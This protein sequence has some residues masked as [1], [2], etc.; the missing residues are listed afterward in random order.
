M[1][2]KLKMGLVGCGLAATREILPPLLSPMGRDWI[3]VVAVC[4][5]DEDRAQQVA[6]QFG[7]PEYYTDHRK[8][9]AKAGLDMVGVATPIPSHFP[10]ALDAI[11]AGKH[12]YIQKTMTV[13]VDDATHLIEAAKV[14]EVKLVSSPGTHLSPSGPF[15]KRIV[16]AIIKY[17]ASGDVGKLAWGRVSMHMRHEHELERGSEGF[18]SIDPSW[19]YRSGGGPLRDLMV[20]AMHPLTWI[21]GPAKKVTA[22]SN[23]LL[24]DREW[25]SKRI[26]VEIDDCTT[27]ILEFASGVQITF[28][29]SFIKGSP[30]SPMAELVG[31][32][33]AIIIGGRGAQGDVELWVQNENQLTYG[34]GHDLKEVLPF[35]KT[36]YPPGTHILSD[37]LHLAECIREDKQPLVSAEHARHVIEIIEKVYLAARSGASQYL[38]TTFERPDHCEDE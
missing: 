35:D 3:E 16:D 8:M 4:D 29:T 18:Q 28:N 33:G 30:V 23:I 17:L 2:D 12:T 37:I 36:D 1:S 31:S 20:Y 34:F 9:L 14:K 25:K 22:V 13:S 5:L 11:N 6:Q 15:C 21:L 38:T 19:Y 7:V 26:H 24:P 10:I 32:Q 27:Y